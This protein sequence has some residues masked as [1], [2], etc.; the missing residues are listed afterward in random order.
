MT[1]L[2]FQASLKKRLANPAVSDDE[3]QEYIASAKR[4]V[5]SGNYAAN[6]Y[7]EQILDTACYKLALDNKFPEVLST[8]Q[9]GLTT[10]FSSGDPEKYRRRITERRQAVLIGAGAGLE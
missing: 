8:S 7:I 4:E 5:S 1:D 2:E 6:D 10:S 9:N 3:L